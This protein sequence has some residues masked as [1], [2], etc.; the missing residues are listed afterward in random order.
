MP[1]IFSNA[2]MEKWWKFFQKSNPEAASLLAN[3]PST[4]TEAVEQ[5]KEDNPEWAK[6]FRAVPRSLSEDLASLNLDGTSHELAALL[7]E[8][9]SA[10]EEFSRKM[11]P[12]E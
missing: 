11:P 8:A 5:L 10:V 7:K 1:N 12:Q 3:P 2:D 9:T 6:A 4:V